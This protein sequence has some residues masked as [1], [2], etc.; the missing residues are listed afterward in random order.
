MLG[1]YTIARPSHTPGSLLVA[2]E[3]GSGYSRCLIRVRALRALTL[4]HEWIDRLSAE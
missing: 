4:R 3:S 2:R 1:A